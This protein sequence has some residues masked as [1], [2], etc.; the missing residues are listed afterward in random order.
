[1]NMQTTNHQPMPGFQN[2]VHDAGHVFRTVLDAMSH[3][4]KV[5][6]LADIP[7]APT[8]LF[9][10]TAAVCLALVDYETPLWV[11]SVIAESGQAVAHLRFY[12]GCPMVTNPKEA[13]KALVTSISQVKN[14]DRFHIGTDERP[15]TSTTVVVQV[16]HVISG[17]GVKLTGPGIET[18]T[19]LTVA[20]GD[21]DFWQSVHNNTQFFPRGVDLIL[22]TPTEVVC[23][24][25]TTQ[26]E[27]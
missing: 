24:P 16:G 26:V 11:D 18:Q 15:D 21:E 19:H 20:G 25:R 12:C 4:G 5:I 2:P 1:M 6:E 9:N 8:P 22:T 27:F 14:L 23:L 17:E 13:R 7:E 3:P 10:T